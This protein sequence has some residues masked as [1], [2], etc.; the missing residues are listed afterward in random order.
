MDFF[1]KL[2]KTEGGYIFLSHSHKDIDKVRQ[3]RNQLEEDGF[4][5]LCFY[6]KCLDDANEIEDL[7]KR[8]IDAREWFIFI[9][10]PNS[11]KSKWVSIERE[12]ITKT[13]QKKVL[14][15]DINDEDSIIRTIQ[16][17]KRNLRVFISYSTRD[18]MLAQQ[19]K[20]AFE[21]KDYQVFFYPDSIPAG[22][23]Y[24][25]TVTNAIVEASQT[26]CVVILVTE[27][28][29]RSKWVEREI[30]EALRI[31]G[32]ILPIIVGNVKFDMSNPTWR[33]LAYYNGVSLPANPTKDAIDQ[34][35]DRIGCLI[36]DYKR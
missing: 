19:I 23:N 12:Y 34:M 13:N 7:I 11:Q 10:S 21:E 3:I 5:P 31:K 2:K 1:K 9:N 15:I 27:D 14:T 8:E 28:S 6:L 30:S 26:G 18:M 16:Q 17:I 36:V 25:D 35:I 22:S 4:E 29:M 33:E 32:N 24:T 20:N